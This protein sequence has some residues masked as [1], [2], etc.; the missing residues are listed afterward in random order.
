MKSELQNE[1]TTLRVLKNPGHPNL[2]SLH[3]DLLTEDKH[4]LV[5]D[6]GGQSLDSMIKTGHQFSP[7]DVAII[8]QQLISG[9][10]YLQSKGIQHFDIKP[11]NLLV[12][13]EKNLQ[14]CD[15]GLAT[16]MGDKQLRKMVLIYM[17]PEVLNGHLSSTKVDMW[18]AGC[19]MVELLLGRPLVTRQD[20]TITTCNDS[21]KRK[22]ARIKILKQRIVQAAADIQKRAGNE[23]FMLFKGIMRG[24]K[25]RIT[26]EQALNT[27]FLLSSKP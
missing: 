4:Y 5:T 13:N 18:S 1:L 24:I 8:M 14:I 19:V 10:A 23:A 26:P 17:P 11:D 15:L 27:P 9:I 2:I 16:Q 21:K 20:L 25:H 7:A 3:Y 12:D 6:L 22:E